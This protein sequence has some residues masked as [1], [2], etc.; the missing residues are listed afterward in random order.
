MDGALERG[1]FT[2][3]PVQLNVFENA[4]MEKGAWGCDVV[5]SFK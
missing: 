1:G 5:L 4:V 2:P 3:L